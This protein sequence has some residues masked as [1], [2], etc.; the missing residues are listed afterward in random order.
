[1]RAVSWC[2][3]VLL[4]GLLVPGLAGCTSGSSSGPRHDGGLFRTAGGVI[5]GWNL[6]TPEQVR[7]AAADGINTDFS[8]GAPPTPDSTIGKALTSAHMHVV[9]AQPANLVSAYECARTHS[10]APPPSGASPLCANDS[11]TSVDQVLDGVRGIAAH[12]ADNPLVIG[13][14]VLDDT[15]GWDSGGLRDVLRRVR[16]ALPANRPTV[17]G[18]SAHLTANGGTDWDRRR[19]K[20]FSADGC[21]VVAPYVYAAPQR[22]G[23]RSATT[24]DWSMRSA[25]DAIT[26]SL[27]DNGWAPSRQPMLG[28]AQAFSGAHASNATVE[29]APTLA[30]MADQGEAYCAAGAT[31]I[32]WYAWQLSDIADARTPST[33]DTMRTGVHSALERCR[34]IWRSN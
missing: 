18:F 27:R 33:D 4:A 7:A 13:Y 32:A 24:V 20:N 23:S 9:S 22:P 14:W 1:M 28:I 10:V 11:G 2:C 3:V 5:G 17:C 25:L 21:D 31:A 19:A 12:D 15:A 29:P 8:Y 26:S 6:T 34:Q 30:Q 16:A